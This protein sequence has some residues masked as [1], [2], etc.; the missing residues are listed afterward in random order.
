MGL[1][2]RRRLVGWFLG[3]TLL[4]GTALAQQEDPLAYADQLIR[5]GEYAL[6]V[7]A[8]EKQL[9]AHP[10]E[11]ARLLGVVYLYE[12][13]YDRALRW[14]ERARSEGLRDADYYWLKGRIE[15]ARGNWGAA[16]SALRSAVALDP[17]PGYALLWG[18]AGLA[19]GD[20]E[21][22]LLGLGKASRSGAQ[23][24]A[25][26]L[27]GL[28]LLAEDPEAALKKLR[29]AQAEMD[30]GDPRKPQVIYWQARALE[31]LGRA[32]EARSTLRFLLRTYPGYG[33]AQDALNRLGP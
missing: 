9:S 18:V 1:V 2:K 6:A 7:I 30:P 25:A 33:P 32:G 26:F 8:L 14:L 16:W 28:A 31:R 27:E 19:Q 12:G 3:F 13:E 5:N 10:K 24:G 29:A 17:Q 15:V 4:A 22:A 20:T 23:V 21:R 11:A